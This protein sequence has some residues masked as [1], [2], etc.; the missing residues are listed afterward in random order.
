MADKPNSDFGSFIPGFDFLQN[1]AKGAAS[2]NAAMP[3]WN[4][5]VASTMDPEE[6]DKR[7]QELKS[8]QFWLDQNARALAATVQALEV[9][10]MTVSTL[11]EMNVNFTDMAKVFT[12]KAAPSAGSQ[13][14]KP[15][16]SPK[17]GSTAQAASEKPSQAAPEAAAATLVDPLKMWG[18]LAQQ[19][20]QIAASVMP[21]P[22]AKAPQPTA[23]AAQ[24]TAKAAQSTKAAQKSAPSAAVKKPAARQ[25]AAS[26]TASR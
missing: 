6:L 23:K 7:I 18:A 11:K 24:P 3:A 10:K 14:A 1:L 26:K 12:A 21:Q 20:Q 25:A 17:S 16:P 9:Q 15:A 13:T 8:V 5:W 2:G 22:S 4:G 19:F